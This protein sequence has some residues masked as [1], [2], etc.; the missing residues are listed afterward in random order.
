[1]LALF[2]VTE[3]FD[4]TTIYKFDVPHYNSS[5][6]DY[7]GQGM[8]NLLQADEYATTYNEI[9]ILCSVRNGRLILNVFCKSFT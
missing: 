9:N 7:I 5:Y 1:V 4:V 3:V 2:F 8:C 6:D